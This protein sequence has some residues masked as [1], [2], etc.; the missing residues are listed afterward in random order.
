MEIRGEEIHVDTDEARAGNA[1][2]IVRY[3]LII[4][5]TLAILALSAIWIA[6]ALTS[7]NPAD[8]PDAAA[9]TAAQ[10]GM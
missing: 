3:V 8:G 1:P 2:S 6:G 9:N 4:S 7:D 10:D 5:L